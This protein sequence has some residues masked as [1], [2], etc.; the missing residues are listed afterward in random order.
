MVC[1]LLAGVNV[2]AFAADGTDTVSVAKYYNDAKKGGDGEHLF[3]KDADEMSWLSSLPTWN[4]EGVAWEAPVSSSTSVYR[5]YNPNSGEHLYVDEGYANYLAGM[6]WNKEKLAFYSDDEMG[7]PVYRLWNGTDGVGSHHFTTDEGEVAWLVSQGWTKEDIAFYGVDTGQVIKSAELID[8]D[9]LQLDGTAYVGDT[10]QVT[11]KEDLGNPTKVTWYR[12]G[13]AVATYDTGAMFEYKTGRN[14]AGTWFAVITNTKGE[15]F[16]SNTLTV[17]VNPAKALVSDF[18]ITEDYSKDV[19]TDKG[20]TSVVYAKDT[21]KLVATFKVNKSEY[22]GAVGLVES[23]KV[24]AGTAEASDVTR[25]APVGTGYYKGITNKT[26]FTDKKALENSF[27]A[28]ALTANPTF[29]I[30]C[31]NGDGSVTYKWVVETD[32]N[33]ATQA[34]SAGKTL[35]RGE[36]YLLGFYQTGV[37]DPDDLETYAIGGMFDAPYVVEPEEIEI[38]QCALGQNIKVTI[39]DESGEAL[40]WMGTNDDIGLESAYVYGNGSEGMTG[41]V[42]IASSPLKAKKGVYTSDG[43]ATNTYS[44][45]YAELTWKEGIF[46]EDKVTLTSDTQ[47][48]ATKSADAMNLYEDLTSPATAVVKFTNLAT[49]GNVFIVN[50]DSLPNAQKALQDKKTVGDNKIVGTAPAK[51][52]DGAVRVDNALKSKVDTANKNAKYFAFFVPDDISGY[53][54]VATTDNANTPTT[55]IPTEAPGAGQFHGFTMSQVPAVFGLELTVDAKGNNL[56]ETFYANTGGSIITTK[57][58]GN[59]NM[60]KVSDQFGKEFAKDA[61]GAYIGLETKNTQFATDGAPISVCGAWTLSQLDSNAT[62]MEDVYVGVYKN[63]AGFTELVV[64][65][66]NRAGAGVIADNTTKWA[67][68]T[69][70]GQTVTASSKANGLW[71]VTIQ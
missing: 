36:N 46:G 42:K 23:E 67:A 37:S 68:V 2:V 14:D 33:I 18:T 40:S 3:T 32:V 58:A 16:K 48:I 1:T 59:K 45:Y 11:Y 15:T 10:L 50:A 24:I 22:T 35:E 38:T 43:T 51:R 63:A 5:C 61:N 28:T 64:S 26:D 44:Y 66:V 47:K 29:G 53:S 20:T 62:A 4:N 25:K 34:P 9:G 39:Y 71:T 7:V 6:G 17:S 27:T 8:K 54:T 19:D 21:G 70:A 30:Y 65:S 49:D 69:N 31:E 41:A 57:D 52:G 60:V 12:N 55:E 13:S 56:K